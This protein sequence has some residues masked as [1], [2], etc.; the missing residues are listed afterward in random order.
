MAR[1][2]ALVVA[3]ES[4]K[5]F[6]FSLERA[7]QK[8]AEYFWPPGGSPTAGGWHVIPEGFSAV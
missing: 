7:G 8:V 1:F 2:A 3:E 6:C 4:H 5:I